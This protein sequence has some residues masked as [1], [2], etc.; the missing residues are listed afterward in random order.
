MDGE[1]ERGLHPGTWRVRYALPDLP[2]VTAVIPTGGKLDMLR[3]CLADLVE[4]TYYPNLEILLLDNSY[5]T[6]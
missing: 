6:R 5:E 4:R 1:V 3:P 2:G